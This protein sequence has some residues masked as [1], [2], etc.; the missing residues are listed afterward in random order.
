VRDGVPSSGRRRQ[1]G[2]EGAAWIGSSRCGRRG[3]CGG[4]LRGGAPVGGMKRGRSSLKGATRG[5]Q[6][7]AGGCNF[8]LLASALRPGQS[9]RCYRT[10]SFFQHGRVL[11]RNR[12]R[13][14]SGHLGN[15]TCPFSRREQAMATPQKEDRDLGHLETPWEVIFRAY[16]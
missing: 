5:P 4:V 11:E 14:R 7:P 6:Q 2:E 3:H 13:V 8:F 1:R 16:T 15:G 10:P 12:G 9:R